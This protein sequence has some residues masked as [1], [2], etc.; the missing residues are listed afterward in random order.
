MRQLSFPFIQPGVFTSIKGKTIK[1]LF[2]TH[3]PNLSV[4][5]ANKAGAT[6]STAEENLGLQIRLVAKAYNEDLN[7]S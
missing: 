7:F 3:I 2:S 6:L 5:T 1:N 4:F